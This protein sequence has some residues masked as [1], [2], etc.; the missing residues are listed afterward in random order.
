[1]ATDNFKGFKPLGLLNLVR[2]LF[3]VLNKKHLRISAEAGKISSEVA[4]NVRVSIQTFCDV[5]HKRPFTLNVEQ[6]CEVRG[7]IGMCTI[8]LQ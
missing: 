3:I 8:G 6:P 2:Y 7:G 4:K 5:E 1:V